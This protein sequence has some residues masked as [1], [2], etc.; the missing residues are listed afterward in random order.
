MLRISS[1][2]ELLSASGETPYYMGLFIKVKQSHNTPIV[3][4]RGR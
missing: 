4:Q 3:E 2:A 1:P